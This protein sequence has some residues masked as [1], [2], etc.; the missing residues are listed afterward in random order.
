M[1]LLA[2][3][4]VTAMVTYGLLMF[5][6]FGFRPIELIIGS[7]VSLIALCYLVEMFIAPVDWASAAYHLVTPELADAEALLLA[8]G[9]IGATVMPHAIY[10]H[11]GLTQARLP[12]RDDSERRRVLRF[13]NQ[14]VIVALTIAGLINMAMVMMASSAF[15]AGHPEVA[16]IE[17]AYHTLTPLLGTAAAG[18]FLLSLIASG[19]SASTVGT[20]AGQMI[21]QGF[22]GF[23]IPIW[24]RRLVTMLPA[25]VVVAM[26]VNATNALVMS[27]VV[28]SIALPLPMISLLIFT[29]RTDIMGEFANNRLTHIAALVGTAVVLLLNIFLI[30]QTLGIPIPGLPAS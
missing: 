13:S 11:S 30:V 27:Q 26:G 28:L 23:R 9:I 21:M 19:I 4:V 5:E 29:R 18:V 8:V 7:M 25:F 3:M 12:V 14:E 10:L 2:G 15:H 6:G 1:P 22:V 17:T 16:E 20:M 24:L